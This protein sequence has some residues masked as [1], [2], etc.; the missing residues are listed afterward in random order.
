MCVSDPSAPYH[1]FSHTN[2]LDCHN[3]FYGVETVETEV[4]VEV[5]FAVEL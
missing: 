5:R 2:L 3:Y 1:L 4:V